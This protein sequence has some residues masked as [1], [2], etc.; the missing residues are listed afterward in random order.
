MKLGKAHWTQHTHLFK[1]DEYECSACSA[2]HD[3]P[4]VV[5]PSCNSRMGRVKYDASWVDEMAEYD[6]IFGDEDD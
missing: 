3:K 2:I 4:Y 5:C 1:K 6:E